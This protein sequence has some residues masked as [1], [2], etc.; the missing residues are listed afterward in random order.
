MQ[1]IFISRTKDT[2]DSASK[3]VLW[4]NPHRLV[5]GRDSFKCISV[6]GKEYYCPEPPEERENPQWLQMGHE[7]PSDEFG[8]G[9]HS[10]E[11]YDPEIDANRK[12]KQLQNKAQK[13]Y[14]MQAW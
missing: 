3:R 4:R 9:P 12:R 10:S 1:K 2:L 6:W 5:L 8:D 13:K 11:E 14:V 7:Y